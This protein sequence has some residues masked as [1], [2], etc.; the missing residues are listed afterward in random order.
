MVLIKA[1][2]I[3]FGFKCAAIRLD[4]WAIKLLGP[5]SFTVGVHIVHVVGEAR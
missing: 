1:Y 3:Y 5:F 2:G 4:S